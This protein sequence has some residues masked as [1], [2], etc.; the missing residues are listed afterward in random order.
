[1]DLSKHFKDQTK[2]WLREDRDAQANRQFSPSAMDIYDTVKD[3]GMKIV[4]GILSF[5]PTHIPAPS[6]ATIQQELMV[7]EIG[8]H[9]VRGQTSWISCGM[10]IQEMQ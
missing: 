6:R 2:K 3:K 10:K 4:P 8:V 7:A 1:M 9:S 5:Q